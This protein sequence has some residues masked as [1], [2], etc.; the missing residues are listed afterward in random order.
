MR[1]HCVVLA[2]ARALAAEPVAGKVDRDLVALAQLL[3]RGQLVR[4]GD[5]RRAAAEHRDARHGS[6]SPSNSAKRAP[7][8]S[9]TTATRPTALSS[10]PMSTLPPA[11]RIAAD[12]SSADAV[13]K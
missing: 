8:G 13:V 10:G 2:P 4:G 12:V 7:C 1:S 6:T 3:G 9:V 11:S 5:A